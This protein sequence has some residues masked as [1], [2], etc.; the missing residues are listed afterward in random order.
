LEK[1]LFL[2]IGEIFIVLA[3]VEISF[4]TPKFCISGK[5]HIGCIFAS[6]IIEFHWK[7]IIENIHLSIYVRNLKKNSIFFEF[8]SKTLIWDSFTHLGDLVL[9]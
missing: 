5:V 3:L 1:I 6:C 4:R 2:D 7:N 9:V 8:G